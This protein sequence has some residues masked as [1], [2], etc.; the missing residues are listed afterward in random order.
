MASATLREIAAALGLTRRA[1][2]AR[3]DRHRWPCTTTAT[4]GGQVKRY[5][6][7]DL[8]EDI[9]IAVIRQRQLERQR[10]AGTAADASTQTLRIASAW[11]AYESAPETAKVIARKRQNALFKIEELRHQGVRPSKVRQQV[12]AQMAR[13]KRVGAS[14]ISLTRWQ[15]AV[16][17][18]RYRQTSRVSWRLSGAL[19]PSQAGELRQSRRPL[20]KLRARSDRWHRRA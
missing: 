12:A 18:P 20:G 5:R 3:A 10:E 16:R 4:R 9:Q 14:V 11:T 19:S 7:D 17:G 2:Q 6:M 1:M 8:S 15:K 13:E